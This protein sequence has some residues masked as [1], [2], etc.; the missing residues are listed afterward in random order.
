[1][2]VWLHKLTLGAVITEGDTARKAKE[3]GFQGNIGAFMAGHTGDICAAMENA[4]MNLI[5]NLMRIEKE[6]EAK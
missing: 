6:R 3:M 1:V 5:G 2:A 4:A